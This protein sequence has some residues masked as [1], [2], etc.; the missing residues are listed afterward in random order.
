MSNVITIIIVFFRQLLIA[1]A[2][3]FLIAFFL[4]VS[5]AT[6]QSKL[7]S[8]LNKLDPQKFAASIGK[9]AEKLEDKLVNKSMK[10]LDKLQ[11]QEEKICH[12]LLSTKDSLQAKVAL[13]D[14]KSKYKTL[15]N[16]LKSLALSG[17]ARQFIPHLDSLTTSLKF[18]D[19]NGKTG[20]IKDALGKTKSLQDKF[21]QADEIKKI[22]KERRD[23]LKQQLEKLGMVKQLKQINK[24]VYYYAAQIKEYREILKDPKKIEKKALELLAKTKF[25][26]D[27]MRKNSMLASLFRMPG[28]PNDPNYTASLAGL[29]T[30]AQVNNLVQQQI[31][32]GGPNAQAQFQQ[33]LQ[34]AQSQLQQSKDKVLK[35]GGGS[36]DAVMP[37]G[38]R[39]NPEKTK[40]FMQRLEY[41][42]NM[43]SQSATNY[44]PVTSD[45]GLSAGYKLND[46]S[47]IGIGVSYKLGW[48]RGWDNIRL[49]SQGI[50]FRSYIDWKLKGSF[51]ISGGYEQNY[52]SAFRDFNQLKDMN[53]WQQ[54]GLIG[55]SKV[56]SVKSKLFKKTSTKLLWDF[57]SYKQVPRT[58]PIVFRIGYNLN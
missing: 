48:G 15:Q 51:W 20:K 12:K 56:I 21:Q 26:R 22:I 49:S 25:F 42:A 27:F 6:S 57:L 9:K 14:I 3:F 24:Q 13:T 55:I 32:A 34:G 1:R 18:L 47:I 28:D 38:F 43:Q 39:P 46:K 50:G 5:S 35:F 52:K 31:A 53:A 11:N 4:L 8:I 23:Q 54:S 2:V 10:V 36:S 58:Q 16:K 45:I 30:R 7:D 44:F 29:Q 19:Q 33:N 17:A 40:N 41:S 37:E